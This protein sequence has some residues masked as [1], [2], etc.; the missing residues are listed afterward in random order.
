M[1][2]LP[3]SNKFCPNCG[4]PIQLGS[5]AGLCPQC[6]MNAGLDSGQGFDPQVAAT[7]PR[8]LT[9]P[10]PTPPGGFV[11]PE[12]EQLASRFPQLEILELLGKGGMGAVYK[13]RQRGLDRL[14]ALKI[15]PP[16]IGN[17][18]AFAER[19]AREARA[20]GRLNHPNIVAVYDF[21]Q[22]GDAAGGLYYFLMEY[23]EGANLR[24]AI[25]SGG[26]STKE[27][28]AIVPQICDALQF[29]HD[30]GIVHRDIKPENILI[31]RRGRVKIADFGLAKLLGADQ[32]DYSLTGTNQVMGTLRYMAPE[33]MLGAKEID[34]RAD[35]FSLG[36][37]FYE[38]L[39]G[40]LPV[41]RFAPPSKT[42]GVDVRLDEVVLRALEREPMLRYQQAS[43]VKTQVQ[44]IAGMSPE[45]V[46]Q[47][48]GREY[49]SQAEFLGWP[50]VHVAFG[51]DAR[52]G[53]RKIAKGIIAIG[54]AA[55]GGLAIGGGAIGIVA[56]G[57]AAIGLVT[58]GG[59]SLALLLGIGGLATGCF[60]FGGLAIGGVAVGGC[61]VGYYAYGG[62]AFGRF[63]VTGQAQD[64]A[65]MNLFSGAPQRWPLWLSWAGLL[66][67]VLFGAVYV[68][69]WL[70]FWLKGMD[71]A[72]AQ[73][74]HV[75]AGQD[76][77]PLEDARHQIKNVGWVLI[78]LGLLMIFGCLPLTVS[79]AA[80]LEHAHQEWA[81]TPLIGVALYS[82]FGGAIVVK[83]GIN[84]LRSQSLGFGTFAVVLCMLPITPIALVGLP[85]GFWAWGVLS[86]RETS[87]VVEQE[88]KFQEKDFAVARAR[89]QDEQSVWYDLGY[90]AGYF[91]RDKTVRW[92]AG[93]LASLVYLGCLIMFF[94]FSSG[95]VAGD[96]PTQRFSVGALGEWFT[97]VATPSWNRVNFDCFNGSGIVA[98]V[99][100]GALQIA[101]QI[102]R[103]QT[104]KMHSMF[105][106]YLL[107]ICLTLVVVGMGIPYRTVELPR[108]VP[109]NR[110][111]AEEH[112]TSQSTEERP[113]IEPAAGLVRVE[114][115]QPGRGREALSVL[116]H[117][118]V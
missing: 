89:L 11:P 4:T 90:I 36:V 79:F 58:L 88:R 52:T 65:A 44:Q 110:L 31:D 117:V 12:I 26:M 42:V 67:P 63:T 84:L 62:A 91:L 94:S 9:P 22:T 2:P 103:L 47:L 61:A 19:F 38:L 30:E 70:L 86:R 76:P 109:L 116:E 99:G 108:T 7:W 64:P 75:A 59:L 6:L 72:P 53:K 56:I 34:H 25:R 29:A 35:I 81:V 41:G 24:Q 87:L 14:V 32:T 114:L 113:N 18:P 21:G 106:H 78:T 40:E 48:F 112:S 27:A 101:R 16:E 77:P 5:L 85:I 69:V 20:L 23:V 105:W 100:I 93:S 10:Q 60:A 82:F 104:G 51:V 74:A 118:R 13:A 83:A 66:S 15:L 43:E 80:W 8:Y 107:W 17:D 45:A 33:Q 96:V 46:Q 71:D 95:P 28:L 97:V 57:G 115:L 111:P 73:R 50:L 68:F 98:I 49:R 102:E 39:T 92:L 1:T 3:S 55:I 54:D 37:V